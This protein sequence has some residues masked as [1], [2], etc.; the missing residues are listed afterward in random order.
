MKKVFVTLFV[1]KTHYMICAPTIKSGNGAS[2][3]AIIPMK[4][5]MNPNGK[6][7]EKKQS[8]SGNIYPML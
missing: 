8:S 1:T 5:C 6:I 7:L 3:R 2:E 4:S